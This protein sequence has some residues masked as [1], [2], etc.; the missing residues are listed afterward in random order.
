MTL[1]FDKF[2]EVLFSVVPI[3]ILVL[4]SRFIFVPITDSEMIRFLL[5]SI[6]IIIGLA[7]FLSGAEIGI[8]PIGHFLGGRLLRSGKLYIL[9]S[10]SIAL[11]FFISVAEPDLRILAS[12][13]DLFS[14]GAIPK[15]LLV[16]VVS[17]GFALLMSVGMI[18]IIKNIPLYIV[19]ILI[20]G[21]ILILSLFVSPEFLSVAFDSSGATTGALAVPVIL[22]ISIGASTLKKNSKA[23]EKDSFGLVGIISTGPILAVLTL[24]LIM[25]PNFSA[26]GPDV[27]THTAE[28]AII[29]PFLSSFKSSLIETFLSLVPIIAFFL[30]FALRKNAMPKKDIKRAL[31]GLGYA[32]IGLSLFLCGVHTGFLDVGRSIGLHAALIPNRAPI[33]IVSF[34]LGLITVLAEPAV[35]VLTADIESVTGGYVKRKA[36]MVSLS[37]GVA[38]AISFSVLRIIIPELQLWHFL[39]PGYAIALALTFFT[40]K[41][42][43][44]MAFDAGGVAS[45]PMAATFILAFTSGAASAVE[46]ANALSDG[47]GMIAMVA[48][49]PIITIQILGTLF[50]IK[51][52]KNKGVST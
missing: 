20:Y 31:K 7:L 39:V 36:V 33:L 10:L 6:L 34:L 41:I 21:V 47:F 26:T 42:F 19:M 46:G 50:K 4:L 44:G 52:R 51:S 48:M 22:A 29:A 35:H 13:V 18:R 14:G 23:S 17:L 27:A 9:L 1:L 38:L 32:F 15:F 49:M 2:K 5:G 8:T 24:G 45:G 43:V 11:A 3:V 12:Q 40:P 16:I 28:D 37:L 30:V 25:R